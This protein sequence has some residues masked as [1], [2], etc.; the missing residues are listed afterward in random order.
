MNLLSKLPALFFLIILLLL[1]LPCISLADNDLNQSVEPQIAGGF[2]AP[3]NNYGYA[4][5]LETRFGN[6]PSWQPFC[7][8]SLIAPRYI[9]TAGHCLEFL[10]YFDNPLN[11][12]WVPIY[13]S[14]HPIQVRFANINQRPVIKV[15]RGSVWR[16]FNIFNVGSKP[17]SDLA[18]LELASPAPTAPQ[19][20]A[21]FN[22]RLI[23]RPAYFL[24]YGQR[25][26]SPNDMSRYLQ[27]GRLVIR[28]SNKCQ[29][30]DKYFSS[31]V[32]ADRE[33]CATI[34]K[35]KDR[36][37]K[38]KLKAG[39][40]GGDSG[41]PLISE[42]AG[43]IVGVVSWT[44]SKTKSV[45]DRRSVFA[46]ADGGRDWLRNQTGLSLFGLPALEKNTSVP[47]E[48]RIIISAN[49]REATLKASA[50]G[51]NWQ[52]TVWFS[53]TAYDNKGRAF[54]NIQRKMVEQSAGSSTAIVK[55]PDA[56][57]KASNV[58]VDGSSYAIFYNSFDNSVG[59]RVEG[60]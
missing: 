14:N 10:E 21:L 42:E 31:I 50:I 16:N 36:K 54:E 25:P 5:R 59:V 18:L 9:L 35:S 58:K 33:I 60:S 47:E 29:T 22:N 13:N 24:G 6:E 17:Q 43:G 37:G 19:S 2:T 40:M 8:G 27:K 1:A 57:T 41:G 23:N 46:R 53:A 11:E 20:L 32:F 44:A 4:V 30:K 15:I 39:F 51:S 55:M 12:N 56:F 3:F 28:Q 38:P 49:K 52:A 34:G 48:A 26:S 45:A 7:S